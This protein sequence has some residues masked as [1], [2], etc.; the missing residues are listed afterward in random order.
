MKDKQAA[1]G[2]TGQ[3]PSRP[4]W[5]QV[6]VG[7]SDKSNRSASDK[8]SKCCIFMTDAFVSEHYQLLEYSIR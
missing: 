8:I 4:I 6:N 5:C 1:T 3:P 7:Y 2:H